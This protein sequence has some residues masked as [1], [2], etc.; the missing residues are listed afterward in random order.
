MA[1]ILR[2]NSNVFK[3]GLGKASGIYNVPVGDGST[4]T[5]YAIERLIMDDDAG[6]P[7]TTIM[8]EVV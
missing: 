5:L 1:N 6:P 2:N 8:N 3:D 4:S 7:T